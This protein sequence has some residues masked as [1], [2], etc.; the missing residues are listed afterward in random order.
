MQGSPLDGVFTGSVKFDVCHHLLPF[1]EV[2]HKK[3]ALHSSPF[4]ESPAE[5][6]E[7]KEK[8]VVS[9]IKTNRFI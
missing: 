1:V 3:F 5:R 7:K 4:Q 6:E 8:G 9:I 2:L